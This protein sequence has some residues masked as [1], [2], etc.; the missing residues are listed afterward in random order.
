M[1]WHRREKVFLAS[2]PRP[3]DEWWFGQHAK[4]VARGGLNRT[5]SSG[6]S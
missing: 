3:M 4:L 2:P 1:A 6:M 5:E